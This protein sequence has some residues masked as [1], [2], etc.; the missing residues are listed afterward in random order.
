MVRL[1]CIPAGVAAGS[2]DQSYRIPS[3]V[4]VD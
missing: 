1:W 3:P 4:Y 2:A